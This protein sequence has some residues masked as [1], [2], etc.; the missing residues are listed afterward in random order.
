M[1]VGATSRCDP[2]CKKSR[3]SV[4]N[5]RRYRRKFLVIRELLEYSCIF[6][7]GTAWYVLGMR[8][9]VHSCKKNGAKSFWRCAA[10]PGDLS[11]FRLDMRSR[12]GHYPT[13]TVNFNEIR[14]VLVREY[15][16]RPIGQRPDRHLSAS[17]SRTMNPHYHAHPHNTA[18][19]SLYS[20]QMRLLSGP[21]LLL[22]TKTYEYRQVA[23][24]I[25][26]NHENTI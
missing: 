19:S 23:R 12:F 8:L 5:V 1:P 7:H 17:R 22:N 4:Q 20:C 21:H 26:Q 15:K 11:R 3:K 6:H 14:S 16:T 2:T 25:A 10:A 13:S 9:I 24:K 18:F